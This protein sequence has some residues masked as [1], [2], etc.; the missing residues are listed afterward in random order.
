M[1]L[2]FIVN[3]QSTTNTG[4]GLALDA[5]TAVMLLSIVTDP[6]I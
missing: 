6:D 2:A 4:T 5:G 1:A 3:I